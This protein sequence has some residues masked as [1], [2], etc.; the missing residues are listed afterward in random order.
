MMP[1]TPT[2]TAQERSLLTTAQKAKIVGIAVLAVAVNLVFWLLYRAILGLVAD[3]AFSSANIAPTLLTFFAFIAMLAFAAVVSILVEERLLARGILL[4]CAVAPLLAFGVS[5]SSIISVLLL[6][7]A[8]WQYEWSIKGETADRITFSP[9]KSAQAGLGMAITLILLVIAVTFHGSLSKTNQGTSTL[10]AFLNFTGDTANQLLATE[11]PRYDPNEPLDTFLFR[12]LSEQGEKTVQQEA[13]KHGFSI[14]QSL[15]VIQPTGIVEALGGVRMDDLLGTLPAG[16]RSRVATDPQA[17]QQ[18]ATQQVDT[19]F[20]GAFSVMRNQLIEK[21]GIAA[22][23]KTPIGEVVRDVIRKNLQHKVGSYA[24][25]VPSLFA[26]TIFVTLQIF[27][28]FYTWLV[29]VCVSLLF[30]LLRAMKLI[31]LQSVETK[32]QQPVLTE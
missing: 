5:L 6:L 31:V 21:L 9:T 8:F 13:Q 1:A 11:V 10:D 15:G 25:F 4:L 17:L 16:L 12:L 26:V 3:N 29:V 18:Y 23:G 19:V 24:S 14:T 7:L 22:N 20:Y 28:F 30:W 27:S 2:T 32:K